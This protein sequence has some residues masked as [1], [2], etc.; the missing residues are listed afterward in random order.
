M[1]YNAETLELIG[2]LCEENSDGIKFDAKANL[3][4]CAREGIVILDAKGK[5]LGV[6]SLKT[7]PANCCWGGEEGKDLFITARENIYLIRNLQR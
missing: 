6:I 4:L 5:R 3:F 2:K 7:I 1:A